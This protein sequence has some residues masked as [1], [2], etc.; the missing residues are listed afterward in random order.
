MTPTK[1]R[2]ATDK[3]WDFTN[4]KFRLGCKKLRMRQ[5]HR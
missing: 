5:D 2:Y 4:P 3:M 1:K